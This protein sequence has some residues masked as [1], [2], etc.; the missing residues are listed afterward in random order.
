MGHERSKNVGGHKDTA[1]KSVRGL[2]PKVLG[3]RCG[4]RA[5]ELPRPTWAPFTW[6]DKAPQAVTYLCFV[7]TIGKGRA[8]SQLHRRCA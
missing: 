8:V 3:S 2:L 4:L 5:R 6:G 7:G 1:P